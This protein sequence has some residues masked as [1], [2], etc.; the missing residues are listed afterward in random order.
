M[1]IVLFF[2]VLAAA[3]VM[4]RYSGAQRSAQ[5][6][7]TARNLVSLLRQAREASIDAQRPVAVEVNPENRSVELH[8]DDT[9]LPPPE[10]SGVGVMETSNNGL[11]SPRPPM[12]YPEP[13]EIEMQLGGT[14][15][16]ASSSSPFL[17]TPEG[18]M[19]DADFLVAYAPD[20]AI[21]VTVR[22][23]GTR[24]RIEDPDTVNA[25]TPGVIQ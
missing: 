19:P 18:R 13:L 25:Y 23:Q 10:S 6:R 22:R 7:D 17:V 20:R 24:V 3:M 15:A 16:N 21:T 2:M 8:Y 14:G 5:G 11:E 9:L 1:L 12:F 4:P